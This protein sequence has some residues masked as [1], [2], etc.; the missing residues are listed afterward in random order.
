VDFYVGKVAVTGAVTAKVQ[1]TSGYNVWSDAKT[2]SVTA[3]TDKTVSAVNT[4][5]NELT[6]TGHGFVANQSI[7]FISS[8]D[9]PAP[10]KAG[11]VYF[12]QVVDANT[13]KVRDTVDAPALDITA[14]GSGTITAS[15]VRVFS[16]T[17][18]DTVT[19][20]Q[21]YTPLKSAGRA[22]VTLTN[23]A[24]KLQ[25]CDVVVLLDD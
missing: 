18:Q 22:V 7:A 5:T 24:D 1:H 21:T 11:R 19:G 14:A 12:V 6:V 20:D 9:T 17:H 15:A 3:S 25:L 23:A 16:I 4:T 2:V 10:L 13:I 8:V